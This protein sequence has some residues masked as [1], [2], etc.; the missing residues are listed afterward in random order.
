MVFSSLL[1][2]LRFLP[3]VLM[4]YYISPVKYR[5]TILL[6]MSLLFYA[7]GE[8]R[9]VLVMISS[10]A[11]NYFAGRL[12]DHYRKSKNLKHAKRILVVSIG[13]NLLI[14]GFFKYTD[15]MI[16]LIN[17]TSG[18]NYPLL[19]IALPIGVSFYTFQA[20][21]YTID[22]YRGETDAQKN[23]INFGTYIALFPQLIAG[24]IVQYKTIS[25][26]L[27]SRQ[28]TVDDFAD[29]I[30]YF[31]TGLGK[32]ILI[33]NT[34]GKI[35]S[36]VQNLQSTQ[37]TILSAWIGI[38]AFTLQIYFD[39]SGYSD[40]AIG[41][42]YM[43]GFHF[44]KN[45]NYPYISKNITEFFRRWHI[46]L[47]NWFK[48]YLYIPLGGN[49]RGKCCLVRNIMIVWLLTGIWHGA[50]YNF[51]LWGLYYG[52]I[53]VLEKLFLL[54]YINKLPHWMQRT[55]TLFLVM[56]GWVIFAFDQ[57][58]DGLRY[59]KIMFGVNRYAFAN[60]QAIYLLYSNIIILIIA[61]LGS[62]PIPKIIVGKISKYFYEHQILITLFTNVFYIAVFILCIAYLVNETY[63]PFLYFRF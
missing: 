22:V 21:S 6:F 1:F 37:I 16:Q 29:G 62:T 23:V 14:L 9:Y 61:I 58:L 12:I 54:K 27:Q 3:I 45:F 32:K 60:H 50:G 35:F 11:V 51:L 52:V 41:L 4:L 31:M 30:Q 53:L 42:G 59:L 7:W 56:I 44:K 33:A 25:K 2:L 36:E 5:N 48:E 8:P 39:F 10:I 18:M 17:H 40:M 28:E 20:I 38:I 55:Y 13:I 57:S 15:F 19:K 49:R 43:F 24:P 34:V 47:G 63:N 46:S 26:E